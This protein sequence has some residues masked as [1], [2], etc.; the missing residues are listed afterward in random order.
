MHYLVN[1]IVTT[2]TNV[3]HPEQTP[4]PSEDGEDSIA[5]NGMNGPSNSGPAT[6]SL[7]DLVANEHMD[8]DKATSVSF[9]SQFHQIIH[10]IFK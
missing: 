9:S 4:T 8:E 7:D 10:S 1:G 5:D 6:P 2:G 3:F